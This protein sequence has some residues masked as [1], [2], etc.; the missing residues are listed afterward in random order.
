MT[1]YLAAGLAAASGTSAITGGT[2][3]VAI[4]A[5]AAGAYLKWLAPAGIFVAYLITHSGRYSFLHSVGSGFAW[6]ALVAIGGYVG[7]H[8]G[9]RSILRHLGEREYRNRIA[10]VKTVSSIWGNWFSDP[11]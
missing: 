11:D 6:A 2:W 7:W 5:A 9:G 8:V 10:A 1:G 3:I 4:F